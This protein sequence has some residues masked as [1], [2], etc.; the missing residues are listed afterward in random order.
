[1]LLARILLKER[2]TRLQIYGVIGALTGIVL[3]AAG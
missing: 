1:L 3:L 2:L